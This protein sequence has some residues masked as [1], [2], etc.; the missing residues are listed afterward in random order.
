MRRL[1]TFLRST[2]TQERLN[3]CMV[4]H[5]HT[6]H[7]DNLVLNEV[8]NEF[9]SKGERRFKCLENFNKNNYNIISVLDINNK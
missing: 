2:M 1:K 4:L 9:V 5:I 8:A 7:T 3:S 6:D